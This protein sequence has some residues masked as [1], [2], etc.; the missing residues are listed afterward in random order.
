MSRISVKEQKLVKGVVEGKTITQSAK[1]A[2]YSEKTA[3]SIGSEVLKKPEVQSR[4]QQALDKAGVTNGKIAKVINGGLDNPDDNIKH[5]F[6][7]TAI[8]VKGGY[9]PEKHKV[10]VTDYS[11]LEEEEIDER[12]TKIKKAEDRI[13]KG[14]G[15]KTL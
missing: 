15:K 4:L 7:D 11:E 2:G 14:K 12:L 13:I 9:S 1:D 8:K 10:E 3:Y 6:T 5:K